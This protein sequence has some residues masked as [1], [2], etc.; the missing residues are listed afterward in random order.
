MT[1]ISAL[2]SDENQVYKFDVRLKISKQ[3]RILGV[4]IVMNRE[5][6]AEMENTAGCS[7]FLTDLMLDSSLKRDDMAFQR[8]LE[9]AKYLGR[10]DVIS[11]LNAKWELDTFPPVFPVSG[12]D[13]GRAGVAPGPAMKKVL[14]H[15]QEIWKD[16]NYLMNKDELLS[17]IS[18]V[19]LSDCEMPKKKIKH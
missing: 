8:S 4:F 5:K 9:L 1:F 15:L 16:S 19:D 7:K 17:K 14:M 12:V 13:V 2:L 10:S 18:N 3:E 11:D 6:G